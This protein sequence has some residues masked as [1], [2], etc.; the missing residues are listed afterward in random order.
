MRLADKSQSMSRSPKGSFV[1]SF[2]LMFICSGSDRA[3]GREVRRRHPWRLIVTP[4]PASMLPSTSPQVTLVPASTS[5]S[6]QGALGCSFCTWRLCRLSSGMGMRNALPG[7][8][9]RHAKSL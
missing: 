4:V 5:G 2:G 8:Q 7:S 3:G 6:Q 9:I 1:R